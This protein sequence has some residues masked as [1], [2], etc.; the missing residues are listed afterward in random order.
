MVFEKYMV[1]ENITIND[2]IKSIFLM[3]LAI[4]G[5]YVAQTL[6]CK[7]QNLLTN[8]LYVKHIVIIMLIYFTSS[9][10]GETKN[11]NESFKITILIYAIYLLF[12][13][14]NIQFTLLVFFLLGV[15]YILSTY[16]KYYE[17]EG[18]EKERITNFKDIQKKLT[19]TIAVLILLGFGLY[20]REKYIEYGNKF[21][22]LKFMFGVLTCDSLK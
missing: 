1:F 6:G 8:N 14:M 3:L 17:K 13:K 20:F 18:I 11:P 12:T 10:F 4:S 19:I 21:S 2:I 16:I 15:N 7:T 22:P 9:V 5:G